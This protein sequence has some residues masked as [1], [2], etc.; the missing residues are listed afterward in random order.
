MCFIWTAGFDVDGCRHQFNVN[1]CPRCLQP[2][3]VLDV[4]ELNKLS[5]I[6]SVQ[7]NRLH[8]SI[9]YSMR[10]TADYFQDIFAR[11]VPLLLS[12][13]LKIGCVYMSGTR[14]LKLNISY[15]ESDG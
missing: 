6:C 5:V 1:W 4:L 2:P 3:L 8:C 14:W 7:A 13:A 11:Q 10:R 15:R 12:C 9:Q